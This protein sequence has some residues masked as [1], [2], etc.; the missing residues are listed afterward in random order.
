[1]AVIACFTLA[2]SF[3]QLSLALVNTELSDLSLVTSAPLRQLSTVKPALK[4]N[5][6]MA[7]VIIAA[8]VGVRANDMVWAQKKPLWAA[9]CVL[10]DSRNHSIK[11]VPVKIKGL[12]KK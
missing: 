1:M 11:A 10:L 3:T 7:I 12:R 8:S 6:T 2:I 9:W 5:T 4:E